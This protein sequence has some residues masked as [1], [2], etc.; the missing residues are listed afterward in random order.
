MATIE[1]V[2][3]VME[4]AGSVAEVRGIDPGRPAVPEFGRRL[5]RAGSTPHVEARESYPIAKKRTALF[6]THCPDKVDLAKRAPGFHMPVL[7]VLR[8]PVWPSTMTVPYAP[9]TIV[10]NRLRRIYRLN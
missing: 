9:A 8:F 4:L 7:I 2:A 1:L 5:Y 3:T 10:L 6:Q